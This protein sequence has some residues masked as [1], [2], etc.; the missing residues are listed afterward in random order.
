LVQLDKVE[1]ERAAALHERAIV[2]DGLNGSIMD[3]P[4]YDEMRAGGVTGANVTVGLAFDFFHGAVKNIVDRYKSLHE[5]SERAFLATSGDDLRRAKREKRVGIMIGFQNS[6]PVE[7]D[8]YLLD[9]FYRLGIRI[10]QPTYNERNLYGDGCDERMD[11]GLS[12][13]GYTL[14]ER[15]DALG[16]VI[17][18]SHVGE[19]TSLE[20]IEHSKNACIVSHAN[21]RSLC[22]N[23][24]NKSDELI[25]AVAGKGGVFGVTAF[26]AFVTKDPNPTLEHVLDHLDYVVDLVGAS[27]AGIGLDFYHGMEKLVEKFLSRRPEVWGTRFTYPDGIQRPVDFPDITRG[28]VA[29]GYSDQEVLGILGGNFLRVLDKVCGGPGSTKAEVGEWA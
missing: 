2:F 16:I 3:G 15:M 20:T 27:A 8:P 4:Y 13:F 19:R 17:D 25:H 14:I 26:P 6:T 5:N 29:R 7:S 11:A 23:A 22:D 9:V 10:I 12:K 24:R 21:A 1:E 18:L 28:L